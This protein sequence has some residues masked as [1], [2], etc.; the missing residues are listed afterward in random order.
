MRKVRWGVL[1]TAQIAREFLLPALDR[2]ENAHIEAIASAN[3][4][5]DK[6]ASTFGIQTIYRTYEE[7]LEDDQIDAVYIPL[8]NALHAEWVKKAD[9]KGKH[10]LCEKPAALTAKEAKE[11]LTVCMENNVLFLEGFMYQFHPQHQRV[12]EIIESG[13]IGEVRMIRVSLSFKLDDQG[14]N[15]RTNPALGGG[16]LYDVGCYCIHAIRLLTRSEPVRIAASRSMHCVHKV[17]TSMSG[18]MEMENGVTALFDAAM[19]RMKADKYELIGTRGMIEVERAYTPHLFEGEGVI[20]VTNEKGEKRNEYLNGD[21]YKREVELMSAR[22]LSNAPSA[23]LLE[24]AYG[25]VL[26]MD[27]FRQSVES[28]AFVAVPGNTLR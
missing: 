22:I 11:M 6:V 25:N 16:S 15:I 14:D 13:E 7:L 28:G 17:D 26:I 3:P 27:A 24:D 23:E 2:A 18:I 21:Q 9:R 10:V 20:V 5:V 1:S 12:R 4:V 8:P 19:D